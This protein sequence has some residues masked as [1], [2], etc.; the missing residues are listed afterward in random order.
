L[1]GGKDA[2]LPPIHNINQ[3]NLMNNLIV[4]ESRD[5]NQLIVWLR[6]D[7]EGALSDAEPE[8]IEMYN[9]MFEVLELNSLKN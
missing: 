8:V 2:T 5:I 3:G 1:I 4:S 9:L 6:N 7:L